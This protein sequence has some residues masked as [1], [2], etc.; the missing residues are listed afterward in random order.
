[1]QYTFKGAGSK[2]RKIIENSEN[3]DKERS[4]RKHLAYLPSISKFDNKV[5]AAF[6]FLFVQNPPSDKAPTLA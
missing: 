2:M 5:Y 6:F 4:Q 1:M 3:L